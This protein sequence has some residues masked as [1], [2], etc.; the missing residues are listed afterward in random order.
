[1]EWLSILLMGLGGILF[2]VGINSDNSEAILKS[3]LSDKDKAELMKGNGFLETLGGC[4]LIL[5]FFIL[6]YVLFN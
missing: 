1:M 6:I 2:Y 5:G 3:K 4:L